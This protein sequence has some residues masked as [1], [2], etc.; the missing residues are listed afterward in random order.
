MADTDRMERILALLLV[1]NLKG[2][3]QHEKIMQLN[4]AGFS[5]LEIADILELAAAEVAQ[6]LQS[7][8]KHLPAL[9]RKRPRRK[10]AVTRGR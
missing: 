9:V 4:L 3:S 7:T 5:N 2:A 8:R 10:R 1:N 6:S